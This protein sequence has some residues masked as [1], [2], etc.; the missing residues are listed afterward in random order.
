MKVLNGKV[1]VNIVKSG[2]ASRNLKNQ[3]LETKKV[4]E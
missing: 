3:K 4:L 1:N 2:I